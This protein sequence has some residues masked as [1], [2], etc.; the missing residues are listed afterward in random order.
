MFWKKTQF[1]GDS[2]PI[3]ALQNIQIFEKHTYQYLSLAGVEKKNEKSSLSLYS[4]SSNVTYMLLLWLCPELSYF[5]FT[6]H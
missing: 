1:T 3:D 4:I 2:F 6:D 5:C